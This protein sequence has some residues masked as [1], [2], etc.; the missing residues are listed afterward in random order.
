MASE[1]ESQWI[2]KY[3]ASPVV[4][5]SGFGWAINKYLKFIFNLALMK[6]IEQYPHLLEEITLTL[7]G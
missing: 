5:Y 4:R 6:A 2:D 3:I 1:K 7:F